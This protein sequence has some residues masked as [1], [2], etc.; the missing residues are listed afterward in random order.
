[1]NKFKKQRDYKKNIILEDYVEYI[2][3]MIEDG[4][5]VGIVD[6]AMEF[7]VSKPTVVNNVKKI[8]N[9]GYVEKLP[10]GKIELTDIGEKLAKKCKERHLIVYNFLKKIG[11]SD[12]VAEYDSE[13][14]EHYVSEET[15]NIMKKIC[16]S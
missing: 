1:M 2:Y 3:D 13:G 8:I 16:S 5:T 14:I 6:I 11:V 10:Y 15:L 7:D 4:M 9:L 12:K